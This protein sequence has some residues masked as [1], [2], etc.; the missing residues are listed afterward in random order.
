MKQG[1][2]HRFVFG[3]I[4][5]V[6]GIGILACTLLGCTS[7]PK[8]VVP[9]SFQ[10]REMAAKCM[11][12]YDANKDGKIAGDE[13]DKIPSM[14]EAIKSEADTRM[15]TV[16]VDRKLDQDGDGAVSEDEVAKRLQR[17]IDDKLGRTS[18][19]C[20]VM[21]RGNRVPGAKVR[22]V[23]EPFIQ[24][25]TKPASGTTGPQGMASLTTEGLDDPY[26]GMTVGFYKIEIS[27]T[28]KNGKEL[29]PEKYNRVTVLGQEISQGC[30][31]LMEG[32][33]KVD[34]Q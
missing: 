13:L 28:D 17:Y 2:S 4:W 26:G 23:P 27:L 9:P 15:S 22:F 5:Q 14:K 3:R 21:R 25:V 12:L 11:E 16:A 29:I 1:Q 32:G 24:E 30:R 8:R 20:T 31:V 34:L 33:V 10:P 6:G 18:V 7:K 19:T